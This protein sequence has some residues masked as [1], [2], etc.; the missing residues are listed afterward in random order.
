MGTCMFCLCVCACMYV[1]PMIPWAEHTPLGL[2]P[3]VLLLLSR[4]CYGAECTSETTSSFVVN[5]NKWL[6]KRMTKNMR[7]MYQNLLPR[8]LL[9]SRNTSVPK[10]HLC[11]CAGGLAAMKKNN[12]RCGV[13]GQI[14]GAR[15]ICKSEICID[16]YLY[17]Y[18]IS[19]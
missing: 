14:G 12:W 6:Y 7:S 4:F 16:G 5:K 10:V 1:W 19:I 9:R 17:I 3:P 11:V 13:L 18:S 8:E 2:G 15:R